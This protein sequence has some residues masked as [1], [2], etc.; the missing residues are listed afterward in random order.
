MKKGQGLS[1]NV[2]II[3]AILIIVLFVLIMIFTGRIGDFGKDIGSCSAKGGE[4][5]SL[6]S[7]PDGAVSIPRTDCAEANQFCCI[8]VL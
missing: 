6:A 7:C 1:L 4:C 8:D 3:A 5:R 2:V